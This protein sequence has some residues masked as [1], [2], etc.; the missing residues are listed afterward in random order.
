MNYVVLE[1]LNGRNEIVLESD[2]ESTLKEDVIAFKYIEQDNRDTFSV[3]KI[4]QYRIGVP[5]KFVIGNMFYDL[6]LNDNHIGDEK[7]YCF[8][9]DGIMRKF[10]HLT[11]NTTLVSD[12]ETL[13]KAYQSVTKQESKK[14][15]MAIKN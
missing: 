3:E 11:P 9:T 14:L 2:F 1:Y 7:N 15:V 5:I 8:Y 12:F 4:S 10:N 13:N 6:E